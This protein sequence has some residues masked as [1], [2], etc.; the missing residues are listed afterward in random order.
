MHQH[1]TALSL[2]QHHHA[3][4]NLKSEDQ[5]LFLPL[6]WLNMNQT[7][8]LSRAIVLLS[9]SFHRLDLLISKMKTLYIE[10]ILTVAALC[11]MCLPGRQIQLGV[12]SEKLA[13][14]CIWKVNVSSPFLRWP[15]SAGHFFS[16][17][18]LFVNKDGQQHL[19]HYFW[20]LESKSLSQRII[21]YAGVL[22]SFQ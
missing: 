21:L 17:P 3:I 4:Q 15:L 8:K 18:S 16:H 5:V 6:N 1:S 11:V 7:T 19:H 14:L 20:K 9:L 13:D 10:I 12:F 22:S 2:K